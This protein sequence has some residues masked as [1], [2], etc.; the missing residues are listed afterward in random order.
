PKDGTWQPGPGMHFFDCMKKRLKNQDL[1]IFAEDL[2]LLDNGVF[3]LLKLS[4]IPGMNVWQFNEAEMRAMDDE[5]I[6]TRIFYSGTH[7]NQTLAG[8]CE[9]V[10]PEADS[11]ESAS[12]EAG[13]SENVS[14]ADAQN[15]SFSEVSPKACEKARQIIDELMNSNAPW[16]IFQLQ[17]ILLLG[18]SARLNI[19]GTVNGNW[20]WHCNKLL[21]KADYSRD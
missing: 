12:P 20:I 3:N 21:P 2:G 4:G 6:K 14:D 7:D 18:D 13:S 16:V 15:P 5:K 19:P 11:S 17:D 10:L 8:W 9:N 1:P